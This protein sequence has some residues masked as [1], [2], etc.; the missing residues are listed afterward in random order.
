MSFKTAVPTLFPPA[1]R[2]SD[3]ERE[4]VERLLQVAAGEGRLT[5]EEAGERLAAARATRFRDELARLV[6]DLPDPPPDERE[7]R[8]A[9]R[10]ASARGIARFTL[11]AGLIMVFWGVSGAFFF[12]P[13]WILG[14]A[15]FSFATRARRYRARIRRIP[16]GRFDHR[17]GRWGSALPGGARW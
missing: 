7:M 15:A 4:E 2:A 12:W 1:I 16:S 8:R 10:V 3:A 13:F 5:P 6:A 11:V 9:S 14:L 17:S